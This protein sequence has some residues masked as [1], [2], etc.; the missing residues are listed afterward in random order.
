MNHSIIVPAYNEENTVGALLKE[1]KRHYPKAQV[2]AVCDGSSD[3]TAKVAGKYAD[4]V[5]TGPKRGKGAAVWHGIREAEGDI[6]SMIDADGSH[7]AEVIG[8]MLP[9]FENDDIGL[10]IGSRRMGGSEDFTWLREIGNTILTK[11][12][13]VMLGMEVTDALNGLKTFRREI[14]EGEKPVSG[15][16]IE[17]QLVGCARKA[18][19]RIV[20]VPAFE[21][22]RGFGRSNLHSFRDGF[23]ILFE[24]FRQRIRGV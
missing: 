15:F 3:G 5:L 2:I 7:E 1:L 17:I 12:S 19:Y 4:K 10:V 24:V 21:H 23:R 9:H 16:G 8:R 13:N 18:G 22:K 6:I 11:A 20:E 14:I